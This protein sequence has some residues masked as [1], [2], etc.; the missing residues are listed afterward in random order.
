M[1]DLYA[2]RERKH[3]PAI[4]LLWPC[5]LAEMRR[6]PIQQVFLCGG[7][8]ALFLG[9]AGPEEAPSHRHR[10]WTATGQDWNSQRA[11]R[12]ISR[13]Y[14]EGRFAWT[15]MLDGICPYPCSLFSREACIQG[16]RK[17]HNRNLLA[18]WHR[19]PA[20]RTANFGLEIA[21]RN[22]NG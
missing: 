11:S 21:A 16:H 20:E 4:S 5:E 18:I 19:I 10:L 2:T 12:A 15:D 14:I 13:C 17:S 7:M 9:S 8:S 1:Q 3:L 22:R 6:A